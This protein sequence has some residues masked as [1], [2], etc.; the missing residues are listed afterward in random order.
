MKL[1]VECLELYEELIFGI[2]SNKKKDESFAFENN[3][4]NKLQMIDNNI[5][6]S[7]Q[8]SE[9]QIDLMIGLYCH[10]KKSSKACEFIEI[11][12]LEM[13]ESKQLKKV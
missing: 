4:S 10:L 2:S 9:K 5:N 11:S 6:E 13:L 1:N 8:Y 7:V 12:V 3:N